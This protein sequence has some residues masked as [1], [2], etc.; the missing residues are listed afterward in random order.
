MAAEYFD[1]C[2][3]EISES[4]VRR[5]ARRRGYRMMKSRRGESVDNHGRFML[6]NPRNYIVLGAR[7]DATVTE[8]RDYLGNEA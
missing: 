2:K 1:V 7:F 6:I 3:Q 8:I 5:M 4:A